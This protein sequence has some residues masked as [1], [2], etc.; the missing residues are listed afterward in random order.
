MA[1]D[2]TF[3]QFEK[4]RISTKQ[5][6]DLT[7]SLTESVTLK[8]GSSVLSPTL[9]LD[10]PVNSPVAWNYA[11]IQDFFRYYFVENWTNI[12][13][14]LWEVSLRVDV[15]GTYKNAIGTSYQFIERCAGASDLTLVDSLAVG[16]TTV[17]TSRTVENSPW[18]VTTGDS[19]VVEI[20][21]TGTSLFYIMTYSELTNF[22]T[23]LF[24][25][26]YVDT[27]FPN[28]A[29][30]YPELKA[31]MNPMQYIGGIRYY[32]YSLPGTGSTGTIP[33][34]FGWVNAN[35]GVSSMMDATVTWLGNLSFPMH[36]QSGS[37]PFVKN[38]PYSEYELFF[39]PFGSFPIDAGIISA[40]NSVTYELKMDLASGMGNLKLVASGVVVGEANTQ[41]GIEIKLGQTY[42][43]PPG[44]G[45]VISSGLSVVSSLATG[46]VTGALSGI[47]NS[48]ENVLGN[49]TPK[50]RST[51]TNGSLASVYPYIYCTSRFQHVKM[52]DTNRIGY[53]YYQRNNPA[54]I[55]GGGFIMTSNA[56]VD[57]PN[58][59]Q[60][61][62]EEV[63]R[64]MDGGFYYE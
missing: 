6:A 42:N 24:S 11:Y 28:W 37:L 27:V 32:P 36:P 16:R 29:D 49:L 62:K 3:Y 23:E 55:P 4:D 64:I 17:S 56:H 52:P 57:I 34:G 38:A 48:V 46:N 59:Y 10:F 33:V 51:G 5:P 54:S 13:G 31:T 53:L 1:I 2:V 47:A 14:T 39:P 50:L 20:S 58:A 35:A 60:T 63:E 45:N 12:R 40:S 7:V 19:F 8:E 30:V 26:N 18:N 9:L 41:I 44:I 43:T 61:E 25:D 15:M 22:I 21:G